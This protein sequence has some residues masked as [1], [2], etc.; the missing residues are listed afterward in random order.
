VVRRSV[1]YNI[2]LRNRG[3]LLAGSI[4][5]VDFMVPRQPGLLK[6][7]GSELAD[8]SNGFGACRI[9]VGQLDT[10]HVLGQGAVSAIM[11][12]KSRH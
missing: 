10:F 11:E 7:C 1:L 2:A 6:I 9:Q 8:R 12:E 4:G 5:N 3:Q